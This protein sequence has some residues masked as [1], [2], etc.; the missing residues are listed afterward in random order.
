MRSYYKA[1]KKVGKIETSLAEKLGLKLDGGVYISPGVLSHIKRRH[2]KQLTRGVKDNLVKVIE[3]ILK[4][5]EYVGSRMKNSG[6]MI[7]FI[8]K[9]DSFLLLGMEID[10]EEGYI[11]VSTLYPITKSKVENR[12]FS[13]KLLKI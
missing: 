11:Y 8:K 13:G 4:D 2:N 5:P 7:E 3:D 6:S 10:N 12:I 9:V 1:Y